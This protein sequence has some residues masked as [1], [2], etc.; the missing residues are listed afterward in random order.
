MA[1]DVRIEDGVVG[2]V[3]PP[4]ETQEERTVHQIGRKKSED[5]LR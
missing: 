5:C 4:G 1:L 3:T 2:R